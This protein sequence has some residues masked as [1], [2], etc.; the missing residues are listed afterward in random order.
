MLLKILFFSFLLLTLPFS[1]FSQGTRFEVDYPQLGDVRP[2]YAEGDGLSEYVIYMVQLLIVL[3]TL[4]T[5]IALIRGGLSWLTARGDPMKIKEGKERITG[6]VFGLIIVLSSFVFLSNIDPTLVQLKELEVIEVEESFPPGIYISSSQIIPENIEDMSGDVYRI[7]QSV[8]NLEDIEPRAIR[9]A[10]QLDREGNILNFYYAVVLHELSAFR[11]RC[12]I[13]INEDPNP[14]D[15]IVPEGVSS[16]SIIQVN[17]NP[18]EIGG[19]RVYMRP[20]FNEDYPAETLVTTTNRITPLSIPEVWSI[21]IDGNY[22]VILTSGDSWETTEN[23]CGVFLEAK[24]LSDLKENHMNRCNPRRM[25]P[26]FA[27]YESCST[28]YMALPLFR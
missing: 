3:A 11:G 16:I 13:F 12:V 21:D 5:V 25:M 28:H 14:R 20:D 17:A 6:S 10:N 18:P 4:I 24:P 22:G 19:V 27:A 7:S 26:F 1:T 2:I 9:L 15:F 23:G 8:R